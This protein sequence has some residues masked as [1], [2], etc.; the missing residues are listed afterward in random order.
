MSAE[1]A[2]STSASTIYIPL[3]NE[4]TSV[5]RPTQ[6]IKLGESLYRVLP[7]QDY[8]PKDEQWAFPPGSVVECVL[9]SRSGRE[10]LVARK[11]SS[12]T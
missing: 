12:D 3:L 5:V 2:S 10:V 6:G 4:G 7:T 1:M 8:D 11:R 9:E